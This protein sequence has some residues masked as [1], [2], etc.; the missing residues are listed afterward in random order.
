MMAVHHWQKQKVGSKQNVRSVAGKPKEKKTPW[1]HLS[2]RHGISSA[3]PTLKTRKNLPIRI[4][5]K[6]GCPHLYI[7]AVQTTIQCIFYIQDFLQKF[8]MIWDICHFRSH[9][10]DA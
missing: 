5:L 8:Y 10:K 7:L 6:N 4:K 3:I 2:I 1:I 9:F